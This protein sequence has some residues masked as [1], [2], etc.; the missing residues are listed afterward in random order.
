MEGTLKNSENPTDH[1]NMDDESPL[2][3]PNTRATQKVDVLIVDDRPQNLLTLTTILDQPDLNIV[4]AHSGKEALRCL[5]NQEFAA[6]LLDVNMPEING[7][8]TAALI[9]QRKSSAHTPIIF[10]T[11][12]RD[13]E[14]VFK[15][16][17]LGAVDYILTPIQPDVMRAKVA[18]FVDLFRKTLEIR[19]QA[20]LLREAE[21]KLRRRAEQALA[22]S[23]ERFQVTFNQAA[24]G[25]ALIGQNGEWLAANEKLCAIL[26]FRDKTGLFAKCLKDLIQVQTVVN[27]QAS[28]VAGTYSAAAEATC[29][30]AN[31]SIVWIH[32]VTSIV[33]DSHGEPK[34]TIAVIEDI[35]ARKNAEQE[36][37]S[38]NDA[39]EQRV[40]ERTEDLRASHE[41][42]RRSE[43]LASLGT[44]AAGIAHEIN[45]PVNAIL[46]A[47]QYALHTTNGSS[48]AA[49]QKETFQI[50]VQEAKRC[51]MIVKNVLRFAKEEKTVKTLADINEVMHHAVG[52]ARSYV[53]AAN[54]V[55]EAKATDNLPKLLL[56]S[57]QIEQVLVNLI[58]NAVQA[59]DGNVN[60][61]LYC[62][63]VDGQVHLRVEDNGP[64][65]SE[66]ELPHIF[67]PFYSTRQNRG[68]TGLGLSIAHGIMAD[69]G[70]NI[71]VRSIRG[72]GTT[73]ILRFPIPD[74]AAVE[75][76]R[77][78]ADAAV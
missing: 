42:L 36:L 9:R 50:I 54:L 52:L 33:R 74:T 25:M 57:T 1:L 18:V 41:Q 14:Q 27:G 37:K 34:Y 11:A 67:D 53:K 19:R 72:Q 8:E 60:V 45:N 49:D 31:G 16:Y 56:N 44:L 64:G 47:A 58:Q 35:T 63:R 75:K 2:P 69:H 76:E 51:G 12:F 46:L 15:G 17:S 62:D 22:D 5:L 20:E 38:L 4:Q 77:L 32:M 66:E 71:D 70:G 61:F 23:E 78:Q 10:L 30:C 73:F 59:A 26:G 65:I 28:D 24:V 6:I 7:F 55:L 29:Q 48:T 39:L 21:E 13:E 68:G 43:R 40:V 3:T